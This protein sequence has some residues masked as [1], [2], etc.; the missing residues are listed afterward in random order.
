MHASPA[1]RN[2]A[3]IFFNFFLIRLS[4]SFDFVLLLFSSNNNNRVTFDFILSLSSAN[5]NSDFYMSMRL[6]LEFR[7]PM[8]LAVDWA[9]GVGN[10]SF[11]TAAGLC[12]ESITVFTIIGGAEASAVTARIG[13][14]ENR[15]VR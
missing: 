4:V 8:T 13:A 2:F 9:F 11:L 5:N 12:C 14:V 10:Q 15:T 1:A 7:P 3:L 6:E